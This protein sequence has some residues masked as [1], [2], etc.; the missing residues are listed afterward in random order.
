MMRGRMQ[1]MFA[2]AIALGATRAHVQAQDAG[3]EAA[4]E[5][6][7]ETAGPSYEDLVREAIAAQAAG[8]FEL[9]HDRFAEAHAL[10]PNARTLRGMGVSSF[11]ASHFA[12][13]IGELEGAL[14]HPDKPLGSEL[15]MAVE[16]LLARARTQVGI[17]TLSV[18]P[19]DAD[20]FVDGEPDARG[21]DVPLVL[22]VGRHTL[23]FAAPMHRDQTLTVD[24][25]L[26]SRQ[27][28]HVNLLKL[29]APPAPLPVP[30]QLAIPE[31][32]HT[33]VEQPA[34]PAWAQSEP[35]RRRHLMRT[36]A[37]WSSLGL[38]AAAGIT[39]YG[40][41]LGTLHRIDEIKRVCSNY[42]P[43]TH[44]DC[45]VPDRN[46]QIEDAKIHMFE[47]SLTATSII[48]GAALAAAVTLFTLDYFRIGRH[49]DV[50]V[51]LDSVRV[52][53]TF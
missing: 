1:L 51:A 42:H 37:M 17:V 50:S 8:Q 23:R 28:A 14:T 24:V 11:Q 18:A 19:R 26:G 5:A 40:L 10:S 48:A 4:A 3:S 52:S 34:L 16:D 6:P 38:S 43:E 13:A 29:D 53:G 35:A 47:H 30:A 20:V 22:D 46:R 12:R 45:T 39:A 7:A 41:R 25:Q 21:V 27:T 49:V 9:A 31:R 44:T 36:R 33:V 32:V 15:V 2:L